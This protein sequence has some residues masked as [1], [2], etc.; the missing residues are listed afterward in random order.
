L[1]TLRPIRPLDE[2]ATDTSTEE[3]KREAERK[4]KEYET[5]LQKGLK[6]LSGFVFIDSD[7]D[8]TVSG[9]TLTLSETFSRKPSKVVFRVNVPKGQMPIFQNVDRLRL[10]V[11]G[12]VISP[13]SADGYVDVRPIAAY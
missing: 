1:S 11:F 3:Q 13:L 4:A 6:S 5:E 10:G 8:E 2:G 9:D 12:D 7:F